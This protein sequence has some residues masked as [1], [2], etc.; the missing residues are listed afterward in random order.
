[1]EGIFDLDMVVEVHVTKIF[2]ATDAEERAF[3]PCVN[4]FLR[5]SN[6][7]DGTIGRGIHAFIEIYKP[8][9]SKADESGAFTEESR[10][11]HISVRIG[12]KKIVRRGIIV[13][14]V[15]EGKGS[16]RLG[17]PGLDFSVIETRNVGRN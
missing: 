9:L 1:M 13:N 11:P 17:D 12:H 7:I 2:N 14:V 6:G 3:N 8:I 16:L 10:Q 4:R 15:E 5:K